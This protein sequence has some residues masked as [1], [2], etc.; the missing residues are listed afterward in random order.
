MAEDTAWR[1]RGRPRLHG[2]TTPNSSEG[3]A[4][5]VRRSAL[6]ALRRT[7]TAEHTA[8]RRVELRAAGARASLLQR[9]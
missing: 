8:E 1:R 5:G 4:C 9:A 2:V 6:E 7:R 3:A